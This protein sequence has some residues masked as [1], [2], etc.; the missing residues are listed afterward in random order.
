MIKNANLSNDEKANI[1]Q[2]NPKPGEIHLN[3][4]GD[5][6]NINKES[7]DVV[8][9][10]DTRRPNRNPLIP[11]PEIKERANMDKQEVDQSKAYTDP[12]GDIGQKAKDFDEPKIEKHHI[13]GFPEGIEE[14]ARKKNEEISKTIALNHLKYLDEIIKEKEQKI[15][16]LSDKLKIAP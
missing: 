4:N 12:K 8:L 15:K 3:V 16:D 13:P 11:S 14:K 10:T 6:I 7:Q 1:H 2:K 9:G 5:K